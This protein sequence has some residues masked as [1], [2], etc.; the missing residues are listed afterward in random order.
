MRVSSAYVTVKTLRDSILIMSYT[1]VGLGNK[2]DEYKATRHN[3]GRMLVERFRKVHDFPEWQPD[4]N[5]EKKKKY[6]FSKG[7]LG[8]HEVL[9]ILP[10]LFMNK[11]GVSI[12][13]CF[14]SKKKLEQLVVVYDDVD[15]GF[16]D[17]KISFGR[18]SGGHRGVESIIKG[19][20]TKDFIRLRVGISP[21]TPNGTVKKLKG[22]EKVLD[23][24]MGDLGKKELESLPK[25]SRMISEIL[26]TIITKGRSMAMNIHN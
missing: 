24:L 10:E 17:Y 18:G 21:T 3:I 7:K 6:L 20:K 22:E 25:I 13:S 11:S 23:F 16:N 26:E 4:S 8:K 5:D 12:A 2:G 14:T 19:L 15:L 9:L 1:I